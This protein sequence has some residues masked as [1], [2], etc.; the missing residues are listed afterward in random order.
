MCGEKRPDR[1][2]TGWPL[3]S[4]P[5]VRGK[6]DC[7]AQL[8]PLYGITPAYAGKS[9]DAACFSVTGS[10]S[11]PRMRG[12]GNGTTIPRSSMGITPAYAG[13]SG[14]RPD[15]PGFARGSPPRMRGK[16]SALALAHAQIGITPAYAGKRFS[17]TSRGGKIGDHPRV[18]GEK[19]PELFKLP[20]RLGSPPRMRGKG[21]VSRASSF[22]RGITPAYAGKS[23]FRSSG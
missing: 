22:L 7:S 17:A 15:T 10:G 12:K 18:C 2:L 1:Q 21:P 13:K 5:R 6:V 4:P 23:R 9:P 8:W 20:L 19:C 3:G 16:V 11:P 14:H